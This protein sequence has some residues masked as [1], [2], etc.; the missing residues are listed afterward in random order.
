[1]LAMATVGRGCFLLC[2]PTHPVLLH[3]LQSAKFYSCKAKGRPA[4][5]ALRVPVLGGNWYVE[6][7]ANL[8]KLP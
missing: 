2:T 3:N 7:C 1:M 5:A 8:K 4:C 6:M